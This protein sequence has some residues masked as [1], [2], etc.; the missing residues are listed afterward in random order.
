VLWQISLSAFLSQNR[1][2]FCGTRSAVLFDVG[3]VVVRW[4]PRTLYS[5]L[6]PDRCERDRFLAE[7]CTMA[8]HAEHDRGVPMAEN[9]ARLIARFPHHAEA[10]RAWDARW[11]EMFSGVFDETVEAI[12]ALA[13]RG[14]PLYALTNMPAEKADACFAMSPAFRRFRDIVVSGREGVVKPDPAAFARACARAGHSPH[15]MLFV[16]DSP[17]NVEA[18]HSFGFDVHLFDDPAALRPALKSRGLL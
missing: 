12:E 13:A 1:G 15:E 17:A 10:I 11:D 8:W 14:T 3:N 2:H 5:K 4:D 6:F 18:A 7:V 16:D 9:A